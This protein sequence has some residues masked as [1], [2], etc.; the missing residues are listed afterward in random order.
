[1][2]TLN[3]I[4][5]PSRRKETESLHAPAAPS[6]GPFRTP[7]RTPRFPYVTLI[8]IALVILAS[9]G[10]LFYFSSA[11]VEVTPNSVSAAV[12]GPF[13]ATGSGGTL[14]Y[15]VITAQKIAAQD[16][17][18]SGTKAVHSFASGSITIYNTQSKAQRLIT[19]TRFA[20]PAG[21]IFRIHTAVTIPGGTSAKPGSITAKVFADQAG[22]S[23]N[24]DPTSFTIPG[25]AG[26][27]LASEVYARS[28]AAMAGGA[29]GNVP[30]VDA[31]LEARTRAA[32]IGA[33][34]PD[35]LASIQAKVP[36]GY[37]LINGAA[38]TTFQELPPT[39][40]STAGMV[41]MKEQGTVTAVVFPNAALASA[42]ASSVSGI[43]YQGEPLTIASSSS[44]V[45]TAPGMPNPDANSFSFALT[46]TVSLTYTVDPSRIAAAVAGK[47]RSEAE[48]ALTNYPE[49]K[50]AI[51]ILRP[52]WRQT[53]SQDP[54]T[55]S[56]VVSN[57]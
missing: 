56:V 42:I 21:L 11:R 46:G 19:N 45:L 35:L 7:E 34:T 15:Q 24:V 28:S 31:A 4:I 55:I 2:R 13:T 48:V 32:L 57:P 36:S 9:V 49:V 22:S 8:A 29:S 54:S 25:F 5:P 26:T 10:A 23:Y 43:G 12:Q 44:L 40:S 6:K 50:R 27:P 33:L 38:T 14:P 16:V 51:I 20:T 41:S 52:F 3:D 53:F 37:V 39:P 18:G 17:Q 30:V 1:M 47:T